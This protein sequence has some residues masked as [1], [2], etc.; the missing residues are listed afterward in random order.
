MERLFYYYYDC[1]YSTG[2]HAN[3]DFGC[4]VA[5][6]FDICKDLHPRYSTCLGLEKFPADVA[7]SRKIHNLAA[8]RQFGVGTCYDRVR[9]LFGQC[10]EIMERCTNIRRCRRA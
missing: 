2:K 9:K 5:R 6:P 8:T 4:L 10:D 3:W 7:R 1:S